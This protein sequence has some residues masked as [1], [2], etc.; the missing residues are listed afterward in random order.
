MPGSPRRHYEPLM[1]AVEGRTV[2]CRDCPPD[3]F[4]SGKENEFIFFE[5]FK[6]ARLAPH[7]G[8][9]RPFKMPYRPSPPENSGQS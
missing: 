1:L 5:T 8:G 2:A 4:E 6:G 3:V 7:R 9:W